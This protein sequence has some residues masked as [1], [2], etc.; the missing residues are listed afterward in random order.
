[1]IGT[2]RGLHC[3][4]LYFS[5]PFCLVYNFICPGNFLNSLVSLQSGAVFQTLTNLRIWVLKWFLSLNISYTHLFA[6]L[7]EHGR[8]CP[9]LTIETSSHNEILNFNNNCQT[10]NIDWLTNIHKR[11]CRYLHFNWK[12][13]KRRKKMNEKKWKK[14]WKKWTYRA[15]LPYMSN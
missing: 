10:Q 1:M 12:K 4:F 14:K 13:R 6:Y 8:L 11:G 2:Y 9:H 7:S 15:V 3:F 5:D